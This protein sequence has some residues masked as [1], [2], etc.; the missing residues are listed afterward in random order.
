MIRIGICDDEKKHRELLYDMVSH[1]LFPYDD[2]EFSYYASGREVLDEIV[3]ES[4]VCEQLRLDIQ[5]PEQS[6]F[7]IS[8]YKPEQEVDLVIEASGCW[9]NGGGTAAVH[10]ITEQRFSLS[11]CAGRGKTSTDFFG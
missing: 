5:M 2:M 3:Q 8:A 1:I 11:A 9:K 10:V 6:G 4:C 7:Y